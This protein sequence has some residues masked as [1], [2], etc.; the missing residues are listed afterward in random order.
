[1]ILIVM[2]YI[3]G[4]L[5]FRSQTPTPLCHKNLWVFC[6]YFEETKQNLCI[7]N[8]DP[9]KSK[10]AFYGFHSKGNHP[11]IHTIYNQQLLS[12]IKY[13]PGYWFSLPSNAL[14]GDSVFVYILS[15]RCTNQPKQNTT[16]FMYVLPYRQSTLWFKV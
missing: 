6:T 1:M 13:I 5:L 4:D 16:I 12:L 15:L 10:S 2:S 11:T 8:Q 3:Y 14:D 9:I 7:K